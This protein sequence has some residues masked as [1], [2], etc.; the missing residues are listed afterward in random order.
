MESNVNNEG[1]FFFFNTTE[2][3]QSPSLFTSDTNWYGQI[4]LSQFLNQVLLFLALP[5]IHW[6]KPLIAL[7]CI[8]LKKGNNVI[9]YYYL[10][11]L[12]ED[13]IAP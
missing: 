3:S 11:I 12:G 13:K 2:C 7:A 6:V 9:H 1:L 4:V 5:S 8:N 10:S